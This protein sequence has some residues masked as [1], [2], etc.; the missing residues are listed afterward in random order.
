M[1]FRYNVVFF[2]ILIIILPVRTHN[3]TALRISNFLPDPMKGLVP[4]IAK[5]VQ[6]AAFWLPL[7]CQFFSVKSDRKINHIPLDYLTLNNFIIIQTMFTS[8]KHHT[9][10]LIEKVFTWRNVSQLLIFLR[11]LLGVGITLVTRLI[12]VLGTFLIHSIQ[13]FILALFNPFLLAF[14]FSFHS[15]HRLFKIFKLIDFFLIFLVVI[16]L[17]VLVYWGLLHYKS[18]Y[19]YKNPYEPEVH[20]TYGQEEYYLWTLFFS[21]V[22]KIRDFCGILWVGAEG[23]GSN[24]YNGMVP[25]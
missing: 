20:G 17:T 16:Q 12:L 21:F 25:I 22:T 11:A 19:T 3:H 24:N 23:F 8:L 2:V 1:K 18:A 6:S 13:R 4:S 7:A 10:K 14:T 15:M 5:L 9:Y